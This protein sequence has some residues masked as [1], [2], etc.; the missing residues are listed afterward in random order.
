MPF[1]RDAI[2]LPIIAVLNRYSCCEIADE[3][4]SAVYESLKHLS[5]RSTPA[6][7][8]PARTVT[9]LRM[10]QSTG[11]HTGRDIDVVPYS[12]VAPL[13]TALAE[14][15]RMWKVE[16]GCVDTL[17]GDVE[18]LTRERDT[19]RAAFPAVEATPPPE[20]VSQ[21]QGV[22]RYLHL[23]RNWNDAAI[24]SN[25]MRLL[26]A[27]VPPVA[28]VDTTPPQWQAT[29]KQLAQHL[30]WGSQ[31]SDDDIFAFVVERE[32][33]LRGAMSLLET[34]R[35][36]A[37]TAEEAIKDRVAALS[38]AVPPGAAREPEHHDVEGDPAP[39]LPGRNKR[40]VAPAVARSTETPKS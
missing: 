40:K 33:L 32:R 23:V 27:A 21:L 20:I 31:M 35:S 38:A 36:N 1:S 15:E 12:D 28:A 24:V 2:K 6:P 3:L 17:C 39:M 16:E 18:R 25:A 4:T 9:R 14:A 11:D 29:L 22:Y 10:F 34:H 30:G 37:S 8:T 26:A 19:A 5:A 7:Q 13:L